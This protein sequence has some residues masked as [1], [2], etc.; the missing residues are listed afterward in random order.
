MASSAI[1]VVEPDE[2]RRNALGKEHEGIRVA[3]SASAFG[4]G[5]LEG[6]VSVILAVKPELAEPVLRALGDSDLPIVRVLSIVAGMPTARLE[7]CL[8]NDVP[9]VRAMPNTGV[10]VGRGASVIAGGAHA[11]AKDLSWAESVLGSVG[12][13]ERTPERSIDAVTGLSGSGPAYFFMVAEALIEAGVL[14]GLTRP[15]AA[16][17]VAQTMAASAAMLQETGHSAE[18]L[19]AQVTSPGGT[20]AAGLRVLESKGLRSALIEA[21]A[22]ATE[23]SKN[24]A[25]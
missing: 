22:A 12:I 7:A 6:D 2:G 1:A 20:T 11:H 15:M 17:L 16:S 9:V 21:V 4:N 5:D 18:E 10:L 25:R 23:R 8:S 14:A 19:R 3:A 13:C 24:L